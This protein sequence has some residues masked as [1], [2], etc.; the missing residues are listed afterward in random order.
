MYLYSKIFYS[1]DVF[2]FRIKEEPST[3]IQFPVLDEN[4]EVGEAEH[5][6]QLEGKFECLVQL[7]GK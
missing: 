5:L 1:L 2:V 4:D 6:L 7:E 3:E